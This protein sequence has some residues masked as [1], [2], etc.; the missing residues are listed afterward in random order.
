MKYY[1]EKLKIVNSLSKQECLWMCD[2]YLD[3]DSDNYIIYS[4]VLKNIGFIDVYRPHYNNYTPFIVIAIK[5]EYRHKK[6]ATF[7]LESAFKN[8]R[9]KIPK[10][11]YIVNN[12]NIASINLIESFTYTYLDEYK[13]WREYY[14]EF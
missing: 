10:V 11:K 3:N 7:L 13:N 5:P 1:K 9:T 14:F 4:K 2:G 8:I 12:D 6:L